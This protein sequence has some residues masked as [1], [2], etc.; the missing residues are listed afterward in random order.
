MMRRISYCVACAA[1]VAAFV[2]ALGAGRVRAAGDDNRSAAQEKE[3]KLIE[4]LQ[5]D[6]PLATKAITCKHLALCGS[7]AAIPALAPLLSN[8]KLASWARI[9][10]EVIPDPAA[11]EAFRAA[12]GK[13][14]GRLLVGAINSIGVRRDA[15]ALEALI[16]R[17]KDADA[18][19][20]SAAAVALGRIGNAPAT[21]T[22]QQALPAAPATVRSAVAEGCILCAEK[23]VTEGKTAEAAKLYDLVRKAEVP[24]QRILEATRGAILARQSAG[25]PLL[26]EQLQAAD[27]AAFAIGLRTARELAGREVTDALVAEL[28]RA[29][30]DRQAL[31]IL[32]LA[33]RGDTAVLPA[34]LQTARSGSDEARLSAFRVLE[35]LGDASCVPVLL[36]AALEAKEQISQAAAAVL[37]ELPGK[38]V[39]GDLAARLAKAEGKTR[40]V[41]IQVAGRR[42]IAAAVPALLQAAADAD[43]ATRAAAITALGFTVEFRDL[44]VLIA[45]VAAASDNAEETKTAEAALRAACERMPDREACAEKLVAA[46]APVAVPAKCRFLEILSVLGGAKALQAVGAA[47]KDADPELRDNASR[48]LGEWMSVDAAPVLLD[49]VKTAADPKYETRA[50]RGYI[51]LL[52]Q[53][54][55]PDDQRAAMCRTA[56]QAAK[57]DAE[58]KLVLEVLQRY[59]SV[60]SMRLA[61]EMAKL[62]SLK[63]EATAVSLIIA[64]KLGGQSV[65]V[66]KLLAHVGHE[67]VKVE[68]IKAEYGAGANVKDVTTML[69]KHVRDWPLIVLPSSSYNGV[70]G[71]DPAPGIVK[72]L[73]V[74]Y[75]MNGKAGE[76]S[77]QENATIMLPMPK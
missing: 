54:A 23:L 14:Q 4:V 3:Q 44:T 10:L 36:D 62:P 42:H 16:A 65:D 48:L 75:R 61:V 70:F 43:P 35:R 57:R 26:V 20:A 30:G 37:A 17:L 56:L 50:L 9:A 13:L 19:V 39:D 24:K 77:F 27:K 1:V 32:A 66:Q 53:F 51:R 12:L 6:A 22:L 7:K 49:L 31:L 63:D 38:D 74:Q 72:Q 5:S 40:Q 45:R 76:A 73:K 15:Q 60:D 67:P 21:Q 29:T 68:I 47:A 28:R 52:R 18:E 2:T 11:D 64:E 59:P 55:M 46:M 25:V 8:E 58:K 34:V 41:L 71:G 69:R 33:D